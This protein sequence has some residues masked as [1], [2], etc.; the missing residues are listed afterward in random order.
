MARFRRKAYGRNGAVTD[1]PEQNS[2]VVSGLGRILRATRQG[3]KAH[4]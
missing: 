3:L 2:T 4:T 1:R